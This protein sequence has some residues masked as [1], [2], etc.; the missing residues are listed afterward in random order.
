MNNKARGSMLMKK[1]PEVQEYIKQLGMF[2]ADLVNDKDICAKDRK[3]LKDI[4][5]AVIKIMNMLDLIIAVDIVFG[6]MR[7]KK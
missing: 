5:L 6:K 4:V 3:W 2:L 1:A 7:K